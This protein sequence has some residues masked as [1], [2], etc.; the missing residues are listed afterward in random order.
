MDRKK[1]LDVTPNW[2]SPCTVKPLKEYPPFI[3]AAFMVVVI[4]YIAMLIWLY[5]HNQHLP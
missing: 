5:R 4:L 1:I 3:I 2:L